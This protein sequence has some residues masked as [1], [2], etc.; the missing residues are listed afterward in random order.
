MNEHQKQD[1]G[2]AATPS[3]A[4]PQTSH[5]G[6]PNIASGKYR[7][8]LL[9]ISLILATV[10]IEGLV[11]ILLENNFNLRK[12]ELIIEK[13]RPL[14][15]IQS[16][17]RDI[18]SLG[19]RPLT[20]LKAE[21]D[22]AAGKVMTLISQPD[23][24]AILLEVT[25]A[26]G[27]VLYRGEP[28]EVEAK[29]QRFN[30]WGN[31]LFSRNFE[32]TARGTISEGYEV[33]V[34]LVSWP[35]LPEVRQLVIEY[36][37]YA[38]IFTLALLLVALL[39]YT[40]AIRPLA[41]IAQ[42]LAIPGGDLPPVI[43]RPRHAVERAYNTLARGTR[44]SSV[45][46]ELSDSDGDGEG[47]QPAYDRDR[48]SFWASALEVIRQGMGYEMV[49]WIPVS[50]GGWKDHLLAPE[51]ASA[52]D[53]DAPFGESGQSLR[54]ITG[55]FE[56]EGELILGARGD[57]AW[58]VG[59]VRRR[60]EKCGLLLGLFPVQGESPELAIPYFRALVRQIGLLLT[61][62]LERQEALDRGRYEVS[63]DLSASMGHDLTN[64]LATGKLELE[65]LR[66]AFR[67]GIVEI[68][69]EKRDMVHAALEGLRKT[70]V[71]LQEVVNVYRAFSFTREPQFEPVHLNHLI[72]EVIELYRH[73]TSRQVAYEL[74]PGCEEVVAEADPRLLKLVLFN[75]L[76]NA[77][78]AIADRQSEHPQPPGRVEISC[79]RNPEW[80]ILRVV[81]NGTGFQNPDGQRL[82][83]V[84]L[85][86]VFHFDFTTKKRQGGLGLAW[87]RSIIVDI[88]QGKLHPSNRGDASGACME[89]L[90]PLPVGRVS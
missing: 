49:I 76:A 74:L 29:R 3:S 90:L 73:S 4:L 26:S 43:P 78:Q 8:R 60:D 86:Q 64:I 12:K 84:E 10:L 62:S 48:Q 2:R 57:L 58:C 16:R 61:R 67:R 72:L 20:E 80:A 63:I 1:G 46:F 24:P 87:V 55:Q 40:G 71:L 89:V 54:Q 28:P 81:D 68:P 69:G 38:V 31:C 42:A 53:P 52:P 23:F 9:A 75:L 25:D 65:T 59:A 19:S 44:L 5:I 35:D 13:K 33:W 41:R 18:S 85:Q 22:R 47:L 79:H 88:H 14:S 32:F 51:G 11:L 56:S 83:G 77:T 39:L 30:T 66:T 50:H 21:V 36:R 37:G 15:E 6:I 17:M 34:H 7:F 70:T 82:E 27:V 45:H